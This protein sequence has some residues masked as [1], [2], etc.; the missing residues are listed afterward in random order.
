M[1]SANSGLRAAAG[2]LRNT[3]P[4]LVRWLRDPQT[5]VPG[6][7]MPDMHIDKLDARDAAPYLYTLR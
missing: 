5:V 1:W 2:V 6:N 7:A 3:P 4:N